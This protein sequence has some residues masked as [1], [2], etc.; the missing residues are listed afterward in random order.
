MPHLLS[1]RE[2][3][4]TQDIFSGNLSILLVASE[5]LAIF[6]EK[7]QQLRSLFGSNLFV[8]IIFNGIFMN[9]LVSLACKR[10][11]KCVPQLNVKDQKQPP[12]VFFKKKLLLKILQYSQESTCAR[13][14]SCEFCEIFRN[15]FITEHLVNFQINN[16]C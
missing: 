14:F 4:F 1:K 12:Y 16:L 7:R 8:Y 3:D 6:E 2:P 13:V 9:T 15:I 10:G 11:K 5:L